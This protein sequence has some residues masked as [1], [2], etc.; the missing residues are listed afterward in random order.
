MSYP[1]GQSR[2]ALFGSPLKD[3]ALESAENC[4]RLL[5]IFL[6]TAEIF[7]GLRKPDEGVVF[8]GEHGG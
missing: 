6:I 3:E 1:A 5:E 2:D 8:L 7:D 4:N